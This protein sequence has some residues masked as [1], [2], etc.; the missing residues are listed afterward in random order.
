MEK[1][2][3][4]EHLTPEHKEVF[5]PLK[6]KAFGEEISRADA[7]NILCNG[8]G[9]TARMEMVFKTVN[10]KEAVDHILEEKPVTVEIGAPGGE[11]H[12]E[13]PAVVKW[14]TF[15]YGEGEKIYDVELDLKLKGKLKKAWKEFCEKL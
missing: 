15:S 9:I 10:K 6:L 13:T 3:V 14:H 12:I 8:T 5:L 2:K 1:S 7:L 4:S 11:L